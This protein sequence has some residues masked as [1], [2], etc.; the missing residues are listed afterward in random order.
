MTNIGIF[1]LE[2]PI[3]VIDFAAEIGKMLSK[4]PELNLQDYNMGE[5][6]L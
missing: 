5:F 2:G 6:F 1:D 3:S 4:N